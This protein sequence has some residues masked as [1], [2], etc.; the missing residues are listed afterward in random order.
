VFSMALRVLL[1]LPCNSGAAV[2]DYFR[3]QFWR[4]ANNR[5]R[6]LGVEI[7]LGAIDC[8]PVFARGED[9]AV[10]LETEMHRVFGYDVFP[11][12]DR[13]KGKL[14]R[15]A[16]AIANGLM[17]IEKNFDKIYILLNV[18]AYAIATELAINNFLPKH[19]KQKIVFRYVP[20]NPPQFTKLIVTTIEEIARIANTENS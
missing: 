18:K 10:V 17:R 1:L 14:G 7:T 2:G 9:D 4:V 15:L 11:S 19:V 16:R 6:K 20:G 13:L 3:G 8:I 5:R 12:M